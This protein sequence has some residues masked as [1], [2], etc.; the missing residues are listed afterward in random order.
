MDL[1]EPSRP[2][3]IV[4]AGTRPECLKTA[5]LV[6]ALK[7]YPLIDVRL[8]NSGQHRVLVE[9]TFAHLGLEVDVALP[10]PAPGCSLSHTVA[11]LR[12]RLQLATPNSARRSW[13]FRETRRRRMPA[14]SPREI[15]GFQSHM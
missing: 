7:R 2:R 15:R 1:G 11:A 12:N 8:I 5:S 9:Q 6:R 3:V 4:V 10:G 14:R 13:S